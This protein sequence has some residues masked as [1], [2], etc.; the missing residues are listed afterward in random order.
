MYYLRG[1][2]G[3]SIEQVMQ[4]CAPMTRSLFASII[5]LAVSAT[6]L[7]VACSTV[8]GLPPLGL[9]QID[10][11][12][13]ARARLTVVE[14]TAYANTS[15]GIW[16]VASDRSIS[17]VRLSSP[18]LEEMSVAATR[19]VLG[20][21][22]QVYVGATFYD[23]QP[24]SVNPVG[25]SLFT[26]NEP[27]NPLVT[28]YPDPTTGHRPTLVGID[29][30]LRG[31]G[32][33]V[34][35]DPI[36]EFDDFLVAKFLSDGTVEL[37]DV[38]DDPPGSGKPISAYFLSVSENGY[39]VGGGHF[40]ESAGEQ[41]IV[42]TP[43]GEFSFLPTAGKARSVRDRLD[44]AGIN[45]GMGFGSEI[46]YGDEE[47]LYVD[48]GGPSF[49]QSAL[50]SQSDFAVVNMGD[51]RPFAYYPG[52]VPGEPLRGLQI[53]EVFPELSMINFDGVS[54]LYA[55]DGHIYMTLHGEDGL[56]L[57][58]ARDPSVIPEPSTLVIAVFATGAFACYRITAVRRQSKTWPCH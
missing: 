23:G 51:E 40:P 21:D 12:S 20:P 35:T 54:D 28:W 53:E 42:V 24:G 38:P 58:G 7:F 29:Q 22:H 45:I 33:V 27:S 17:F 15:G 48:V 37:I 6:V 44:G 9:I 46:K 8:E 41:P 30:R 25:A 57:F 16:T 5:L 56:Y 49:E 55:V 13:G 2:G 26:L 36:S 18:D 52:I 11:A 4:G 39:A 10:P 14:D 3:D 47:L 19:V 31:V 34:F 1:N 32:S 43:D 50:V